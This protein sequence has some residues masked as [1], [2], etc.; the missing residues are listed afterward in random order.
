[1]GAIKGSNQY[2]WACQPG[3][4]LHKDCAGWDD[5][6]YLQLKSIICMVCISGAHVLWQCVKSL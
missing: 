3:M 2:G 5:T 4:V 6:V 1:M